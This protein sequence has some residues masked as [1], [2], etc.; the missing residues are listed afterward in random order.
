VFSPALHTEYSATDVEF[1]GLF[2]N[3]YTLEVQTRL[4]NNPRKV[5]TQMTIAKIFGPAHAQVVTLKRA[6]SA[7]TKTEIY[8]TDPNAFGD[9]DFLA[10]GTTQRVT[11]SSPPQPGTSL[12]QL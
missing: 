7:F 11:T 8:P 12:T 9:A 3:Y 10:A 6:S 5:I 4:W 1:A 2:I